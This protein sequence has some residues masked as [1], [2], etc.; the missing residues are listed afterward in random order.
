M[1]YVTRRPR[2]SAFESM[3]ALIVV[4]LVAGILAGGF[5][6]LATSHKAPAVSTTAGLG[7]Q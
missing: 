5:V 4:G 7:S 6:G 1:G 2:K 3:F